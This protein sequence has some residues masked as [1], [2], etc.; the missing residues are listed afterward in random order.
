MGKTENTATPNPAVELDKTDKS[1]SLQ[2][3][4]K[5]AEPKEEKKK[6]AKEWLLE[7]VKF[8]NSKVR[9]T[10]I[11]SLILL[12]I[13]TTAVAVYYCI[14]IWLP[15]LWNWGFDPPTWR[16][17]FSVLGAIYL[18]IGPFIP[19]F[20]IGDII[21][22]IF[23]LYATDAEKEFSS[24][25]NEINEKQSNYESILGETDTEG[26]IPLV[27]FSRIELEQYYKIGL[28]QTQRSYQY[29]I[30]AMWFGFFIIAFGILSYIVPATFINKDFVSGNLQILTIGSGI[31]TELVSALFLWIYKSSINR[32]T[33][34]YNRQVFIHNTLLA[35]KISGSMKDA[36]KARMLIVEKILE[37]GLNASKDSLINFKKKEENS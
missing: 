14:F 24:R 3:E 22:G 32:L 13:I 16:G 9:M 10:V 28:T 1:E 25:I 11:I 5:N 36:D 33:Y 30:L 18:F 31:I 8:Q 7:W 21:S 2:H 12:L 23:K 27:T 35:F 19:F 29:S 4:S 37:F 34:F 17:I 26:L 15:M 20:L 6:E